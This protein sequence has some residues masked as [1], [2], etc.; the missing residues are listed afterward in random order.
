[1]RIETDPIL[2]AAVSTTEASG[3][4]PS[5][6]VL[7]EMLSHWGSGVVQRGGT[8]GK[9]V[10]LAVK[11]SSYQRHTPVAAVAGISRKCFHNSK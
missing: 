3:R 2:S 11:P 7:S 8:D 6:F 10:W 1:M 4:E 5:R 9:R